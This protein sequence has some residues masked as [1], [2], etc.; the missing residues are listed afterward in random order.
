MGPQAL[1]HTLGWTGLSGVVFGG[2]PAVDIVTGLG[3]MVSELQRGAPGQMTGNVART[4]DAFIPF[5][6]AANDLSKSLGRSTFS[7]GGLVDKQKGALIKS[8]TRKPRSAAEAAFRFG[9]GIQRRKNETEGFF[10]K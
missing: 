10:L 1:Q 8:K 6:A 5:Q 3:G 9:T 4:M 7:L 2:G